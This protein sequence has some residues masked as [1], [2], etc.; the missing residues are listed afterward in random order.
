VAVESF[1]REETSRT[2]VLLVRVGVVVDSGSASVVV[3]WLVG[4]LVGELIAVELIVER[5]VLQQ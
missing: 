3:G 1:V 5:C 2:E 4:W